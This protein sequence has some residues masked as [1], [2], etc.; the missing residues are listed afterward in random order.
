MLN[1]RVGTA[2]Q[3]DGK[4]FIVTRRGESGHAVFGPYV[5]L[6]P[7][8][9][10]AEFFI[11]LAE[12]RLLR[13]REK[14]AVLDVCTEKGVVVLNRTNVVFGQL[15]DTITGY[16]LSFKVKKACVAEF[17]VFVTGRVQLQIDDYRAL[18]KVED[19]DDPAALLA[20]QH[21]PDLPDAE[22]PAFFVERR[23]QLRELFD[24]GVHVGIENGSVV[25][26]IQGVRFH[27]RCNDDIHFIGEMFFEGAYNFLA[28]NP[29]CVIDIGMNSGLASLLFATK[30]NVEEVHSFEP[31]HDTFDRA[32]ANLALNPDL[33]RKI[34]PHPI[35]L[36]N[37]NETGEF[38]VDFGMDSGSRS[39][40]PTKDGV[41][42][43]LTIR[44]AA[45][46]LRPIIFN[47][48]EKSLDV[49]MKVDCEGSEFA[50]FESLDRAGLLGDI[51]AFMVEWHRTGANKSILDLAEPLTRHGYILF[52]RGEQGGNGF[53]YAVNLG[54]R[55]T[56]VKVEPA[57]TPPNSLLARL[58][59]KT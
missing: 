1:E 6:E 34:S 26:T 35:G 25:L 23:S 49:L 16:R 7:G 41:A 18:V 14:C 32:A 19:G 22:A 10:V 3:V 45:E 43:R 12:K 50:I 33:A 40:E 30:K 54:K 8:N 42:A 20:E 11:A 29:S 5:T 39:I 2:Q 4:S 13:A 21:F 24:L 51:A 59:G 52:D 27:A 28:P 56:G 9:Y 15:K 46:T 36:S 31:F 44:D 37:K 53:F 57:P 55:A 38:R 48:R 17:R 58:F 47:A